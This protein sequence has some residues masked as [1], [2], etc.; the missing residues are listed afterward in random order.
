[1]K[2]L[3]FLFV[4]VL[5]LTIPSVAHGAINSFDTSFGVAVNLPISGRAATDGA[6]I[7]F[8]KE[9]YKVAN[10]AY[11]PGAVGVI[12]SNPAVEFNIE[13]FGDIPV[14]STGNVIVNVSTSNGPIVKGDAIT[15]SDVQGVGMKASRSGFVIGSALD[16]YSEEDP[17][18]V[19]KISVA[20]NF[21]YL[22]L[23]AQPGNSLF[24]FLNLSALSVY[25]QP[26]VVF[27]YFLSGIIVLIA[28]A[29][30]FVSFGRTAGLGI[31]A[32]GRNPLA[33]RMIQF[34]ILLNVLVTIAIIVAG[35]VIAYF[36]LQI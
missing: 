22:A 20:L 13:G 15:T 35:L 33:A 23:Q 16:S 14:L 26:T 10:Q 28:I 1:M 18:K 4:F 30:G 12:S 29:F 27:R 5:F 7:S 11:D 24:N 32:L 6:I 36:V 19:G 25:E 31:E 9:G 2:Y 3:G 21:H 8:T 17:K 34:G